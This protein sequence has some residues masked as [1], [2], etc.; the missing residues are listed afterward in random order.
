[1]VKK[2]VVV[3]MKLIQPIARMVLMKFIQLFSAGVHVLFLDY[4]LIH[5]SWFQFYL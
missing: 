1:M 3:L 2:E 4:V 5:V